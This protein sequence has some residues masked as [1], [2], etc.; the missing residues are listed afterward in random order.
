MVTV[1]VVVPLP[2]AFTTP[3]STVAT[4]VLLDFH[5][6][7]LSVALDGFT[8]AVRV[9]VSPFAVNFTESAFKLTPVT[10]T[11]TG[12]MFTLTV[13]VAVLSPAFAVIVA[14]PF[15]TA[16]T[17]PLASTVATVGLLDSNATFL[18]VALSGVTF[19]AKSTN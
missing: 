8:V 17:T 16:Y 10:A 11:V 14:V 18:F 4:A 6:T 3:F 13:H 19:T 1:I 9:F 7:V 5:V 12:G 15:A 2:T